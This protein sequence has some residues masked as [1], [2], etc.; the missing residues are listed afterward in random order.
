M[1]QLNA[2]LGVYI[3][4]YEFPSPQPSWSMGAGVIQ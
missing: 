2:S 1:R 3:R 4:M